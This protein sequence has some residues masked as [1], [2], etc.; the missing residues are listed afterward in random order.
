MKN[1]YSD[2]DYMT[3]DDFLARL[4]KDLNDPD[5]FAYDLTAP[6]NEEDYQKLLSIFK[7]VI[8]SHNKKH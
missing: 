3:F 6:R 5:F 8:A 1:I 4:R 2:S 7:E